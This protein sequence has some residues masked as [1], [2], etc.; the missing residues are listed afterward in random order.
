MLIIACPCALG[1]A[2]PTALAVSSGRGSQLGILVS[3]PE[4]LESTRSIDT[5]VL[6]K[7]GTLTT[8]VM[9]LTGTQ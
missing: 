9:S 1:L 8:G 5:V 3:G 6:D 2:T 7:T 4:A